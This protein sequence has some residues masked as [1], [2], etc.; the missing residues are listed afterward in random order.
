M[1]Q[2]S[3]IFLGYFWEQICCQELAKIAQSGH[4][5]DDEGDGGGACSQTILS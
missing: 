4:T 3:T 5:D 2:K 1:A